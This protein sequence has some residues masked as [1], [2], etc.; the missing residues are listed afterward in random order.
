M[1]GF[2]VE[3][4]GTLHMSLMRSCTG[5]PSGTW[6]DPPRRTAPDGSNFQLQHWTHTFDY[7][8]VSGDGDWRQA[9]IPARSAE[10]SRP[11]LA[12]SPKA[13]APQAGCRRGDRCW[14]SS[15]RARWQLGALKAAG[16][17]LAAR[18]RADTCDPADGV[19]VRLVETSGATADVVVRSGL[20]RVSAAARVD[21][22][23]QPRVQDSR[24]TGSTLHG[25]RDRHGADPAEH[26]AGA[27]RGPHRAGARRR[28][29]AAAV[30]AVLAAQ[31][32]P[33]TAR[34]AARRR[35]SASAARRPPNRIR[36]CRCGLP[37][38]ATAATRRCTA[39]C[40]CCARR[41]GAADPAE[42][43]FVLPPGEHLE[44][45]VLL[46][47]PPDAAAGAVSGA[48]RTGA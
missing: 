2:A 20:R 12:S 3:S 38:P 34:R 33:R 24:R 45:D 27:R 35:A 30:R 13:P 43:P 9:E 6:I 36:E 22:L 21:L 37:W 16:N 10:F 44:T 41:A 42:L 31:P 14:R 8:L 46:T 28:S 26:A 7:A 4:D 39:R 17:P 29:G 5:W 11:L 1:P 15:P 48:R 23:E 18:Q 32:R 47:M 25:Y 19:A 40:G